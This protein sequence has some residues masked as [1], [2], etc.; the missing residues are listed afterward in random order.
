MLWQAIPQPCGSDRKAYVALVGFGPLVVVLYITWNA[1]AYPSWWENGI[2]L[3]QMFFL[4]PD[5]V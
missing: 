1:H 5:S 2:Q 4:N 3:D